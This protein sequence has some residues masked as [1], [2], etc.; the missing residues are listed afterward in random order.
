MKEI[1]FSEACERNKE[2]ILEVLQE[3]L[4]PIHR[5]VVEVGAGT[6]QHATFFAQAFPHIKWTPTEVYANLPHLNKLVQESGLKNLTPP[7]KMKVGEDDI[8]IRTY[9]V[10]YTANTFHIMSWK[11]CKTFMKLMGHRLEK[12]GLAIIYGPF[13]YGGK[14]ISKSNEEFDTWLKG[15]DPA[16][17]VRNFE[18]VNNT[19][20]KNGFE[21][22]EDYEM[23]ANNSTLVYRRLPFERK[24]PLVKKKPPVN[25]SKI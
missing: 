15:R 8:P 3:V 12:G 20:K 18:D 5:S 7:F 14:F 21:L 6:G 9:D 19:M 11:D 13:N 23:P 10:I 22:V 2:P 25:K 16:S 24:S 17:G 4:K 1:P